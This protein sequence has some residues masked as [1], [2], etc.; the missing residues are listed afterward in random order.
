[1]IAKLAKNVNPNILTVIGGA[2]ASINP[3]MVI[4]DKNIDVVVV[5]EGML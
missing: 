5:G 3:E 4:S 2:H 1:M